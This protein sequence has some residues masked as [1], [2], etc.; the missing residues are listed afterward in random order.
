MLIASYAAGHHPSRSV[1]DEEEELQAQEYAE[2]Y[3]TPPVFEVKEDTG[4][5][6][7]A[8]WKLGQAGHS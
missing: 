3:S 5:V 2:G 4:S 6:L 7:T 1:V 8:P